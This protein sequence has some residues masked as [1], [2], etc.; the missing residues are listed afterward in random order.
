[1]VYI[2]HEDKRKRTLEENSLQEQ[3]V[4]IGER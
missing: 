1:M 3:Q 4:M 2:F